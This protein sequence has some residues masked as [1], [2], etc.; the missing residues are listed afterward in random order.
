MASAA[1]LS[2]FAIVGGGGVYAPVHAFAAILSPA[3]YGVMAVPHEIVVAET[4]I[5]PHGERSFANERILSEI[6]RHF[7]LGKYLQ[8]GRWIGFV[9]KIWRKGYGFPECRFF[10]QTVT[11]DPPVTNFYRECSSWAKI[12]ECQEVNRTVFTARI[13]NTRVSPAKYRGLDPYDWRLKRDGGGSGFFSGGSGD[14]GNLPHFFAGLPQGPSESSDS[15]SGEGGN[16]GRNKI[17][18]FSD[19]PKCDQDYVVKG[20][21]LMIGTLSCA[22]CFL[23][24]LHVRR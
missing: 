22:F 14:F 1:L 20:A 16:D 2:C 12:K 19:L 5:E 4:A 17:K 24:Y 18:M 13:S 11:D 7:E 23:A 10:G 8:F 9:D 3:K 6:Q 21:V 15:D